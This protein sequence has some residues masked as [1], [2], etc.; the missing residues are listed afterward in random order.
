MVVKART[1]L[2]GPKAKAYLEKSRLYEPTC[3]SERVGLVWGR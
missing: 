1:Q 3:M 2:P